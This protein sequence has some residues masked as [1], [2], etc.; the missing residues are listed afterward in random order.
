MAKGTD[1]N[2]AYW[3]APGCIKIPDRKHIATTLFQKRVVRTKFYI[4]VFII[5]EMFW[6]PVR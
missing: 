2:K 5:K 6:N 3:G 1:D 4:Y